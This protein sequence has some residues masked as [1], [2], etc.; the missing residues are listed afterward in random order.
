[1]DV[2]K[3]LGYIFM[4]VFDFTMVA[5]TVYLIQKYN[6]SPWWFLLTCLIISS[7]SPSFLFKTGVEDD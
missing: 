4:L 5:G 3:T 1:M 7:S 6:W 2:G